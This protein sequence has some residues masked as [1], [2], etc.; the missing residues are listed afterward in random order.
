[1]QCSRALGPLT[2]LRSEV[3]CSSFT[4]VSSVLF[5][6]RTCLL[7]VRLSVEDIVTV[8]RVSR[9]CDMPIHILLLD[10]FTLIIKVKPFFSL[11]IFFSFSHL[12][13][14]LPRRPNCSCLRFVFQHSDFFPQDDCHK[15]IS[16]RC[17][18]MLCEST[19]RRPRPLV[20]F[21]SF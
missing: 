3:I 7:S 15:Y 4:S 10:S 2:D 8:S 16:C 9:I 12:V 14:F 19:L 21:R 17:L 18:L 5:M 20:T 6:T 11:N 1:M 13:L